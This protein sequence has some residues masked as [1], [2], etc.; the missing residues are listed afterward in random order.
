MQVTLEFYGG[1]ARR[2]A[3]PAITIEL[4]QSDPTIG[5]ALAALAAL[6]PEASEALGRTA[7]A[8]GDQLVSRSSGAQAGMSIALLPPVAGG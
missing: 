7:C 3:V 4:G 2:F 6:H 8:V 5:D 1:L